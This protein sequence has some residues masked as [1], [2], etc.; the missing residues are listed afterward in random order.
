MDIMR[1]ASSIKVYTVFTRQPTV[2]DT[3]LAIES[4]M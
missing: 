4:G 2:T 1:I 3:I